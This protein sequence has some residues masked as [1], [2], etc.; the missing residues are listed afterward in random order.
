MPEITTGFPESGKINP[1]E[2]YNSARFAK[3]TGFQLSLRFTDWLGLDTGFDFAERGTG[4][5]IPVLNSWGVQTGWD[6][7][8]EHFRYI[9]LPIGLR[10][11]WHEFFC[12]FGASIDWMIDAYKVKNGEKSAFPPLFNT[13]PE[14]GAY[15]TTGLEFVVWDKLSASVSARLSP[16]LF[17]TAYSPAFRHLN[18]GFGLGLSYEVY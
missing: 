11:Q 2:I 17:P 16:Q 3:R 15:L 13:P 12:S 14:I 7:Y 1:V 5:K 9:S 8:S 18:L 10:L 4:L 6:R